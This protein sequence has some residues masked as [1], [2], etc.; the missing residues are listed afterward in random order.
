[1]HTYVYINTYIYIYIYIHM[2]IPMMEILIL[3]C[4]NIAIRTATMQ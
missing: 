1:M 3:S 2:H 4:Y